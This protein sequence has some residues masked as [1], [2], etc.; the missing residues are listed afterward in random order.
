MKPSTLPVLGFDICRLS[1]QET[2]DFLFDGIKNGRSLVREDINAF[3]FYLARRNTMVHR[4]LQSAQIVSADGASMVMAARLLTGQKVAR[5]TGVDL[6]D[7]LVRRAQQ[8]DATIYLLGGKEEIVSQLAEQY[9]EKFG[10]K[11]LAGYRNGYFQ[12]QDEMAICE[13]INQAKP[14]ILFIGT[15]SPMKEL[16]I[17]R[18]I[19]HLDSVGLVMGVGGAFDVLSGR[20]PRAPKWM[21]GCGL[22]WAFRL[23]QE[24]KRMWKR[25]L[26]TNTYFLYCVAIESFRRSFVRRR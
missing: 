23:I 19:Q 13:N 17:S 18:N 10:A 1:L 21:Q 25:Y 24:P 4:T 26:V 22:E 14:S 2:V 6:M 20:I 11:I 15:P 8:E 3:K 9:K 7:Q 12:P 16:F 5:V